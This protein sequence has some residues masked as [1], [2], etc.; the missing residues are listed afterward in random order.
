M[1]SG[2]R[3]VPAWPAWPANTNGDSF[4]GHLWCEFDRMSVYGQE[5]TF[6]TAEKQSKRNPPKRFILDQPGYK[7][8]R[9]ALHP[10][11]V[12]AGWRDG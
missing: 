4:L 6:A 11:F 5:R 1:T 2:C 3:P 12:A 9:V 7:A 10:R 8:D